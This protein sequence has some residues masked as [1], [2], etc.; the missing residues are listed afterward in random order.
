VAEV[1]VAEVLVAE[2][3]LPAAEVA[4]RHSRTR[5]RST[6]PGLLEGLAARLD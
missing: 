2:V 3:R 4:D 6:F 1:L 5:S